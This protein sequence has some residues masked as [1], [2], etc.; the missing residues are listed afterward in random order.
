MVEVEEQE[1]GERRYVL[2]L[3]ISEDHRKAISGGSP[4]T[5]RTTEYTS[6]YIRLTLI[7][8]NRTPEIL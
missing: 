8:I 6:H 1:E 3:N 5:V 4:L 2:A 7:Q